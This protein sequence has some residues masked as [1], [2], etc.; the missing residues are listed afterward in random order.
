MLQLVID[1]H[2]SVTV[3]DL[4]IFRVT[5]FISVRP[6]IR[7]IVE[8]SALVNPLGPDQ[9]GLDARRGRKPYRCQQLLRECEANWSPEYQSLLSYDRVRSFFVLFVY[10]VFYF[11]I[12]ILCHVILN[13]ALLSCSCREL[14]MVGMVERR[15]VHCQVRP[16]GGG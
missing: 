15:T 13:H 14:R 10:A 11:V 5:R 2:V 4:Y 9:T 7:W 12:L 3:V 8:L 1:L 16:I 6:A